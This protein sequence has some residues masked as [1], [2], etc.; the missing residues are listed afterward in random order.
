MK[1]KT[2]A[3]ILMKTV[4]SSAI[5]AFKN[6]LPQQKIVN[7]SKAAIARAYAVYEETSVELSES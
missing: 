7:S 6:C 1:N 2:P 4:S 3:N 5:D